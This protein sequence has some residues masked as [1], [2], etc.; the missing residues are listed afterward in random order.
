MSGAAQI[1][2]GRTDGRTDRRRIYLIAGP[3]VDPELYTQL[4]LFNLF[5]PPLLFGFDVARVQSTY[6]PLWEIPSQ[7]GNQNPA[8]FQK[9]KREGGQKAD[10]EGRDDDLTHCPTVYLTRMQADWTSEKSVGIGGPSLSLSL[11]LLFD[12]PVKDG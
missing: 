11:S 2:D 7:K 1:A 6:D 10:T 5:P 12:P 8:E 4:I 3:S 9:K